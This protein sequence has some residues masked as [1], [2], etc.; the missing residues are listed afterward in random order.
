MPAHLLD[1]NILLRSSD[2]KSPSFQM[3]RDCIAELSARGDEIFV[4][5]QNLVEFWAVATRSLSANGFGWDTRR[6]EQEVADIL[7]QFPVLLD[8]PD[9][10]PTWRKLVTDHSVCGKRTH[11][12]R[13]VAVMLVH[14]IFS[15][16]TLNAE[17]FRSFKEITVFEPGVS[18]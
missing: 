12:A 1:T 10:F 5:A 8:T 11:D 15:I 4:T 3:T 13:L 6:A 14:S 9:I 2:P 17:D 16:V 18:A 7:V